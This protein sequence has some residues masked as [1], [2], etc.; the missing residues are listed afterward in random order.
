VLNRAP[1]LVRGDILLLGDVLELTGDHA[2]DLGEDDSL[3][4]VPGR[5]ID[6][7]SIG[8][9]VVGK[10]VVLQGE[11]QLIASVGVACRGRIQNS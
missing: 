3:H 6:G 9:D 2:D 4:V 1:D 5:V 8:E 11:Q 10:F 7:R